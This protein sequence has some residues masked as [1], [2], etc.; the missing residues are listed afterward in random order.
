MSQQPMTPPPVGFFDSFIDFLQPVAVA[1]R[2]NYLREEFPELYP[3]VDTTTQTQAGVDAD[4]LKEANAESERHML[5]LGG[6]AV[7][8]IVLV[9]L[10][11]ARS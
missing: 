1:A 4:A 2:D 10:I 3:A 9:S 6:A 8:T 11:A 7:L 5:L